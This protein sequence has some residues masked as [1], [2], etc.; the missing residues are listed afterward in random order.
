MGE[1]Q[2][3]S[4]PACGS[5]NAVGPRRCWA[6]GRPLDEP[7]R[8]AHASMLF[9]IMPIVAVIV[10]VGFWLGLVATVLTEAF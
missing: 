9:K 3:P 2:H 7:A 4:C 1:T 10:I 8:P 5:E 6:C